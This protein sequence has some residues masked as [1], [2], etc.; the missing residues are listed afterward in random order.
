VDDFI[1]WVKAEKDR[2]GGW[3]CI[4]I[5]AVLL[6]VGYQGVAD[7]PFVAEELAYIASGGLGGLFFLGLGAT[8]LLSA[9]LRDEW[10]KL[11]RID[12]ALRQGVDVPGILRGDVDDAGDTTTHALTRPNGNGNG[13]GNGADLSPPPRRGAKPRAMAFGRG[14]GAAAILG[15]QPVIAATMLIGAVVILAGWNA[16]AGESDPKHAITGLATGVAGLILTAVAAAAGIL[17]TRRTVHVRRN[18][19][20]AP[21]FLHEARTTIGARQRRVDVEPTTEGDVTVVVAPGLE[22]YHRA[23]CAAL[24]DV[25]RTRTVKLTKTGKRR[26]CGLCEAPTT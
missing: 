7:S 19:I 26:P 10:R 8:L 13:N 21:W 3:A 24:T 18:Q 23:G 9:D 2:V 14:D 5:G 12:E 11:D 4:A 20:F 17:W 25:A 15:S 1:T 22:R 6:F 16:A